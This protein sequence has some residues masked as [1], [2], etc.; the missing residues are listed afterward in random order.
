MDP[1]GPCKRAPISYSDKSA[2]CTESMASSR[3]CARI[4]AR[5]AGLPAVGATT[6]IPE[7]SSARDMPAGNHA[8][9]RSAL[10][11]GVNIMYL[12]CLRTISWGGSLA[13][14]A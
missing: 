4:P 6:C 12:L 13:P 9:Q 11:I 14:A 10:Q 1:G 7:H 3:S 2:V 5:L 8:I